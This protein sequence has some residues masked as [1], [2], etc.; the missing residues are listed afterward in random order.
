MELL[1]CTSAI[2]WFFLKVLSVRS[3]WKSWPCDYPP[4]KLNSLHS[5]LQ[6]DGRWSFPF[7]VDFFLQVCFSFREGNQSPK[8]SLAKPS[9]KE[10][11]VSTGKSDSDCTSS[12]GHL[13]YSENEV[14]NMPRTHRILV[15]FPGLLRESLKKSSD[16]YQHPGIFDLRKLEV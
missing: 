1:G 8:I 5:H 12:A 10:N 13:K 11:R 16:Q 7:G 3:F 9:F 4:W 6:I 15:D 14:L 2:S